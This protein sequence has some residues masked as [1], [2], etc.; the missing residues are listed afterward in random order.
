MTASIYTIYSQIFIFRIN[1]ILYLELNL[2]PFDCISTPTTSWITKTWKPTAVS[3]HS[4][5]LDLKLTFSLFHARTHLHITHTH[6]RANTRTLTHSL[7]LLSRFL[8]SLFLLLSQS[9]L[10]LYI[11]PLYTFSL[12]PYLSNY[13]ST[14]SIHLSPLK[15]SIFCFAARKNA[16]IYSVTSIEMDLWVCLCVFVCVRVYVCM[17]VFV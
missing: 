5:N 7:F 2:I 9:I 6:S 10:P 3:L 11:F 14:V 4:I 15:F 12:P 16:H 8:L 1:K 17:C 13:H